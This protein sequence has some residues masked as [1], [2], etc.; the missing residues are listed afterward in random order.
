M[1][2]SKDVEKICAYCEHGRLICG[3]EDVICR[4]KGLVKA[5]F[6]CSR[7][8]YTPLRRVPPKPVGPKIYTLNL[9]KLEE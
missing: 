8:L 7:F 2:F 5:Q 4:K 3:T 6:C 1:I 9:P